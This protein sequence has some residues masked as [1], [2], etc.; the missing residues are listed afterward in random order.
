MMVAWG[1]KRLFKSSV[2]SES[3]S[4]LSRSMAGR[5]YGMAFG[6]DSG[7]YGKEEKKKEGAAPLFCTFL[8]LAG[9]ACPKSDKRDH[10]IW[11]G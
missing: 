2:C 8:H 1:S 7:L 4:K 10:L 11:R 9:R 6:L 3:E 5:V